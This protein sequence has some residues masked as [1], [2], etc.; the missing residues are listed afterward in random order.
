MNEEK[1]DKTELKPLSDESIR[2]SVGGFDPFSDLDKVKNSNLDG[3][4]TKN[5]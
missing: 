4:V 2:A 5:G 3:A 1:Q